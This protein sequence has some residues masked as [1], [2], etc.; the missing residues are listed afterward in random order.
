M[1]KN[2]NYGSFQM[3]YRKFK[4]FFD[5]SLALLL[6]PALVFVGFFIAVLIKIDSHGPVIIKQKRIGRGG[7]EFVCYKFRTMKITTPVVARAD[8]K[9]AKSYVT[10]VGKTLRK[11]GLDELPQII[12][13][14][15]GQMSFVGPRPLLA[16]EEPVHRMRAECG[17]YTIPPGITGLCQISDRDPKNAYQRVSLDFEYFCKKS[18]WFDL[19]IIFYTVFP[20]RLTLWEDFFG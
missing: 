1:S 15:K 8:L 17:I 3:N 18:L 6:L 10:R 2:E 7:R 19:S 5:L 11:Y 13:V 14:L 20:K 16:C 9:N 4:R 12:N